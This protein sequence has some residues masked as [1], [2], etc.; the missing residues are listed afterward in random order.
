MRLHRKKLSENR[1]DD[2]DA[3]ARIAFVP[4]LI[5]LRLA[6]L[7]HRRRENLDATVHIREKNDA[8]VTTFPEGWLDDNPLTLAS[9]TEEQAYLANIGVTLTVE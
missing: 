5:C 6:V 1:I 9:L 7:L 2:L 3:T 4:L 8:Y